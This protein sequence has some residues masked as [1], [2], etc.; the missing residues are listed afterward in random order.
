MSETRFAVLGGGNGAFAFA[1]DLSIA[2]RSVNLYEDPHFADNIK[3]VREA[4]G[5][6]VT[7]FEPGVQ[8]GFPGGYPR[9]GFGKVNKVTKDI[10]EALDGVDVVLIV[11]AA[12][13]HEAMFQSA[14]PYLTDDQ[15]VVFN[16]GNWACLRFTNALR[17]TKKK[18]T[19]AETETLVYSC[20][21]SG[22]ARVH[23]DGMKQTVSTA[24]LPADRTPAVVDIL[25]EAYKGITKF[26]AAKNVLETSLGN[27]NMVFHPPLMVLNA[28]LV[29]QKKCDFIF[30]TYGCTPSTGR[31]LDVVDSERI[32]TGKALGLTLA[33]MVQRLDTYYG[34]KGRNCYE[35]IQNCK[36]YADPIGGKAPA[37]LEFRYLTED[38]PY[39]LVP[40]S[41]IADQL[42]IPTPTVDGLVSVTSALMG[43]DYWSTGN[44]AQKLGIKGM[45]KKEILGLVT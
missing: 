1:G 16:N 35:A 25:N 13:G 30:Y 23:I 17:K 5:I 11:T 40:L 4:G 14:L 22:S 31:V 18:T 45:T 29:E 38:V 7:G 36:P 44:N 32:A 9:K 3:S 21:K 39:A 28:G 20:R 12:F 26:P 19:L 33:T 42:K 15:T 41:S 10:K 27:G 6:E 43:E 34:A 2:G 24:A 37:S 8:S